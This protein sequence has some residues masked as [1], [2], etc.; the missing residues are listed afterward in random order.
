MLGDFSVLYGDILSYD[1][2]EILHEGIDGR[3]AAATLKLNST[4]ENVAA[5]AILYTST[6]ADGTVNYIVKTVYVP[7]T[8]S[9]GTEALSAA[10]TDMGAVRPVKD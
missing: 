7:A 10:V 6:F 5:K 3:L 9:G 1:S 2:L 4:E 8:L